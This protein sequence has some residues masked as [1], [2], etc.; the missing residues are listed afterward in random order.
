[1]KKIEYT[2]FTDGASLIEE[3]L[4]KREIKRAITRNNLYKFWEKVA[5]YKL[6]QK[7]KP[8]AMAPNGVMVIA[9]ENNIVTQEL[10]LKKL[11]LLKKF[12]P[13]AKSLN[14]SVKDFRFDAKKWDVIN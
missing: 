7:S 14:M 12:E 2:N 5:G 6:A 4:E 10:L 3:M 13:Y 11:Q 8:Y 9:C 1:M